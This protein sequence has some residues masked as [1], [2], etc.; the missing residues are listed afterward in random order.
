MLVPVLFDVCFAMHG[1]GIRGGYIGRV[2][3]E[4]FQSRPRR[5]ALAAAAAC[6]VAPEQLL[7]LTFFARQ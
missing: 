2:S 1:A 3:H 4:D 5:D 7:V 6:E